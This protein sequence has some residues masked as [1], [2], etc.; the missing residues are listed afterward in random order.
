MGWLVVFVCLG[1]LQGRGGLSVVVQDAGVEQQPAAHAQHGPVQA[2]GEARGEAAAAA[3]PVQ[4]H[5]REHHDRHRQFDV[6]EGI[7]GTIFAAVND[8]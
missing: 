1:Q 8:A 6:L 3:Q 7:V 4:G 2:R 5:R